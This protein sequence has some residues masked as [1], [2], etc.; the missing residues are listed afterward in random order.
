MCEYTYLTLNTN[1]LQRGNAL[2][3]KGYII[4]EPENKITKTP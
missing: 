4:I 2:I 1:F 3:I